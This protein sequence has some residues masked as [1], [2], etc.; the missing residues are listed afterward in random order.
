MNLV[1]D[2]LLTYLFDHM[3][4]GVAVFDAD[5]RLQ[6]YNSAWAD[7]LACYA[8]SS[9]TIQ[10]GS[11]FF[12]L[13]PDSEA[14][15]RPILERVL[16]GETV[17]LD[18]L[19][20]ENEGVVSWWDVVFLPLLADDRITGLAEITTDATERGQAEEALRENEANLRS[21]MENASN[22]AIYRI[23]IDSANPYAG[24]VVMVS[25]SVMEITGI[26]DPYR[27]ESWFESVH[28]EDLP[29]AVAAN[30]QAIEEGR[31]YSQAVRVWHPQKE[32]WVWVHT[33]STPVFDDA[34]N[35]THFNGL[36]LDI[37]EQKQA[38][39]AL[40]LA[41]QTME[42]RVRERTGEL[43]TLLDVTSAAITS[44]DLDEMLQATLDRLV[45][46]V[47]ASRAGVMLLNPT[48]GELEPRM[49]RPSQVIPPE[50]LTQIVAA[51][52]VVLDSGQP[53]YIAPDAERGFTEP[54]ALLPLRVR[55]E[56][57]GVLTIIGA[58]GKV[59]SQQQQAL[60]E[61]I[62]DQL[63]MAVEHARLYEQAEQAAAA[64]ERSRLARDLH[65]AVSQTLFSA[66]LI[67]EVLPR[68]WEK[69]P[70]E[71]R[72]RLEELRELTRGAL[73][74]M[75]ALLLELRPLA[76]TEFSLEELLRQ[77]AEA[78]VG[79]SRLPVDVMAVGE[80]RPLPPDVQI[81]FYR[82]AQESLHNIGKHAGASQVSLRLDFQPDSVSLT[83]ADD[84]R[85]F[86][87]QD[88]PPDS[89][90]LSIMRERAAKIGAD[91]HIESEIGQGT[92]V[93]V[94]WPG[95]GKR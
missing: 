26:S 83:V 14:K 94:T 91:F 45:A 84:G 35:L 46:L 56:S 86:D 64:A 69:N 36:I 63:G 49:L 6:Q 93:I 3:P 40:Q 80:V 90:G 62:A 42:Q 60:F 33:A 76:L 15:M 72:R 74:E 31:P 5:L 95:D 66:S 29:K 50:D 19:R 11:D 79:R 48:S 75:R 27:F 87:V 58:P 82:I 73:A 71:G 25:P 70:D 34:G 16:A 52:R 47:Q 17:R 88:T 7:F 41:Y 68:L 61:S 12:A 20:R 9:S 32:Q 2:S 1:S 39:E 92:R 28:P 4:M 13:T 38:E 53:L 18:R 10:P 21:L 81:A 44:L 55:G 43:Q 23:V 77:L 30:R 37:T 65:D 8:P 85:G 89:F 22:F 54:G 59:F 67:A 24:R 57:V 78:A 51:C